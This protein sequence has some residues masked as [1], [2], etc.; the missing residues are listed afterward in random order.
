MVQALREI[1]ELDNYDEASLKEAL[2]LFEC[3][4]SDTE[5]AKDVMRFLVN[6][7]IDMERRGITRTYL[8]LNEESWAKGQIQIDGYF[9]I[10]LKVLY[11]SKDVDKEVLQEVFGDSSRKNCPAYLIGQLARSCKAERGAGSKF[12]KIALE[13]ISS[14]S[15]LVGGRLIYLDC[16]QEKQGYYEREGF[17][18]LQNKHNSGLVQ[19]YRVI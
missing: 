5:D 3:V 15:D 6:D 11:F 12:L 4:K 13:Y 1:I 9:A 2:S 8:V 10:A 7:A 16:T 14:A 17:R 18:F 19:M